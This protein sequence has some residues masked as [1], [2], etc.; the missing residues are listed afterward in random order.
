MLQQHALC[1]M[2]HP[3][4]YISDHVKFATAISYVSA[5]GSEKQSAGLAPGQKTTAVTLPKVSISVRNPG[6]CPEISKVS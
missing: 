3:I 5:G 2:L 6:E 4:S 1:H